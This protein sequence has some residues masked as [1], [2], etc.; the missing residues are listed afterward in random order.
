MKYR[1]SSPSIFSIFM[2]LLK[3]LKYQTVDAFK[4]IKLNSTLYRKNINKNPVILTTSYVIF[5]YYCWIKSLFHTKKKVVPVWAKLRYNI[6]KIIVDILEKCIDYVAEF[7]N[8]KIWKINK[9]GL[10]KYP[11]SNNVEAQHRGPR[12]IASSHNT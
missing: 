1:H 5:F 3:K 11:L 8:R 6:I 12:G 2:K 4:S 9:I 10:A 7:I